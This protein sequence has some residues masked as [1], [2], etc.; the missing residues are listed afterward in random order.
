MHFLKY[1]TDYFS[2]EIK[3][4]FSHRFTHPGF[5]YS[6][7]FIAFAISFGVFAYGTWARPHHHFPINSFITIP[8]GLT[9]DEVATILKDNHLIRSERFFTFFAL[10]HGDEVS[11]KAGEYFLHDPEGAYT[12]SRRIMEGDYGLEPEKLVIPEGANVYEIADL[13]ASK[14][15]S[16]DPISFLSKAQKYEGYLFPDTY[17]VYPNIKAEKAIELMR[18]NFEKQIFD[19]N[20]QIEESG[21]SLDEIIIMASIVEREAYKAADRRKIASVLWN[22]IERGMPLQVDVTFKYINGKTTYDLT[23]EDLLEENPYNTYNRKGLPPTPIA[24]PSLD[25]ILATIEP[26]E[27]DYLFFLA[28]R[29]GNTYFS[30][31]YEEHLRKKRIYV[32]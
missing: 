12:L 1:I 29:R 27:T 31:T 24:N 30:A 18:L 9:L 25:A 21:R 11:V 7:L 32:D 17:Y 19:I 22:R 14:Y 8:E 10:I 28:D 23:T 2:R 26:D 13:L 15:A 4:L 6:C 20:E 16:F 5:F 3:E